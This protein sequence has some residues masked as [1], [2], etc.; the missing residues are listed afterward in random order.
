MMKLGAESAA[1]IA[2]KQK[3]DDHGSMKPQAPAA[4]LAASLSPPKKRRKSDK[5]PADRKWSKDRLY[6][7]CKTK[8]D[9]TKFYVGCDVCSNWFHGACVGITPKMSKKM[10]E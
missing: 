4:A 3:P 1:M 10:S 8:Y 5:D 9:E 2:R 7:V 6:C